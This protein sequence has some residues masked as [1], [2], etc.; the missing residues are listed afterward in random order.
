[1]TGRI[2]VAIVEN[3]NKNVI[4]SKNRDETK[5]SHKIIIEKIK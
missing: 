2:Q 3:G 5:K 1:M 4:W